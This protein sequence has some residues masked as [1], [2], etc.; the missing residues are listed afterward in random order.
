Q[1]DLVTRERELV[2]AARS[3]AR[4]GAQAPNARAF[5][6]LFEPEARFVGELAE[7]DL[8]RVRGAA[9][10]VDV[11]ARAEDA[12]LRAADDERFGFGVLEPD[13]L[14][15]VGELDVDAEIVRVELERV[16][17]AHAAVL[18]D[19]HEE[20]RDRSIEGELP[21]LVTV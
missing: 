19:V 17:R 8:E 3:G 12:V 11:R 2:T 14:E 20:R 15:R 1:Q 16:A 9:E 6:E 18:L 4:Q 10:H 13:A 7:V 5:A 21:V